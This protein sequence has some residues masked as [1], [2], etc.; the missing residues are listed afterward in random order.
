MFAI[1]S[2]CRWA[3]NRGAYPNPPNPACPGYAFAAYVS[4]IHREYLAFGLPLGQ[5]V[6]FVVGS[7]LQGQAG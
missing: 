2:S 7:I 1:Q 4:V 5:R 6:V 3:I